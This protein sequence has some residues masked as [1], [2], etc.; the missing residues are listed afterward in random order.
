MHSSAGR[1]LTVASAI[2][3]LTAA[4]LGILVGSPI[5]ITPLLLVVAAAT[6]LAV[7]SWRANRPLTVGNA[8]A[9]AWWKF[10]VA[11]GLLAG[12]TFSAMAIP[13]P[14]AIDLGDNAYWLALG[15]LLTSVTLAMVGVALGVAS[16]V[17]RGRNAGFGAP[18]A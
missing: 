9:R 16:L 2:V 12:I 7:W 5:P 11:S 15:G 4:L 6:T 14:N 10:L 1:A 13:W 17:H 18:A 3:A 8:A